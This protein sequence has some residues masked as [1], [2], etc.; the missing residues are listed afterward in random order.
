MMYDTVTAAAAATIPS[1]ETVVLAAGFSAVGDA[2]ETLMYRKAGSAPISHQLYFQ[3]ADGAYWEYVPGPEGVNVAAAG[4]LRSTSTTYGVTQWN[5]AVAYCQNYLSYPTGFGPFVNIYI[6]PGFYKFNATLLWN[7]TCFGIRGYGADLTWVAGSPNGFSIDPTS[8][9]SGAPYQNHRCTMEGLSIY[10]PSDY[11][12]NG[13]HFAPTSNAAAHILIR[14]VNIFGWRIGV[15]LLANAYLI[16]FQNV[17]IFFNYYGVVDA[18]PIANAG[19]NISF[20][21][22]TIFNNQITGFRLHNVNASYFFTN[23]SIDYNGL[24][25]FGNPDESQFTLLAVFQAT[26]QGCHIETSTSPIKLGGGSGSYKVLFS[27]A[28]FVFVDNAGSVPNIDIGDGAFVTM[29]G[30]NAVFNNATGTPI[31]VRAG[32]GLVDVDNFLQYSGTVISAD[33]GSRRGSLNSTVVP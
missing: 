28:A 8:Y 24:G 7:P 21:E 27:G 18:N 16:K 11:A 12:Q 17:G 33:S 13:L 10:G 32:G 1:V 15:R 6:P 20:E 25:G 31:K 2:N 14:D 22:C 19:E 4:L 26:F 9:P 30:C 23:T 3:S 29:I 5:K